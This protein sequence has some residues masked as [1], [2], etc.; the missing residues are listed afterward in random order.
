MT[1]IIPIPAPTVPNDTPH[2]PLR[3]MA[4][5]PAAVASSDGISAADMQKFMM[6]LMQTYSFLKDDDDPDASPTLKAD[7]DLF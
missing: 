5:T 3:S 2:V 7:P 1:K 4:E 6:Q